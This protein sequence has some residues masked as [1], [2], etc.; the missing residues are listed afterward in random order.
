MAITFEDI[1]KAGQTI[2]KFIHRTPVLT[3]AGFDER[4]GAQCFFK[5]ENFQRSGSFKMRGASYFLSTMTAEDRK[6]GVVTF[7]SGNHGQAVAMAA[8]KMGTKATV[9]MP[10]DAPKL[11]IE[12]TRSQGATVILYDRFTESREEIGRK[13]GME[14]GAMVAP[15]FDHPWTIT[16][17]GTAAMELLEDVPDLDA[18]LVCVGGGGLLSGSLIAAKAMKHSIQ[19]FG[20]EPSLADD[21][22]QSL[23]AGQRIAIPPST[24]IADGLRTPQPGEITFPIMSRLCGNGFV[25]TEDQALHAVA[26]AFSRLKIV[27]EPGGAVALAAALFHGADLGEDVIA[28]CSGG[29]ID[30]D[31]FRLA[32]ERHPV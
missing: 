20:V 17:Q 1:Q 12:A 4:T 9:V 10:K 5:C 24:T 25:V 11:K 26:L 2:R 15:P 23:R 14:T 7:S 21:W 22:A 19:V 32:L 27:V 18:L 3:S 6:R 8:R 28:V 29:N 31:V 16:G 30:T 13:I